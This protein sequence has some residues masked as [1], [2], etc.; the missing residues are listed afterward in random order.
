[1]KIQDILLATGRSGCLLLD[2]AELAGIPV[3]DILN[4]FNKL[5]QQK[6]IKEDCYVLDADKLMKFF[7]KPYRVKKIDITEVKPGQRY[8]ASWVN[9]PNN[10]FVIMKDNTVEYNTLEFSYC[11]TYGKMNNIVRV[12]EEI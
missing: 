3:I 6:V 8:I 2:Y 7:N 12:L 4:N 11:V 9:E 1:M 5:V 10:H